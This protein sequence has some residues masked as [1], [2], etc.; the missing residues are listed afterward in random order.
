[1]KK[2]DAKNQLLLRKRP[3]EPVTIE[4]PQDTLQSLQY[5]ARR[6][7]MSVQALL[8]VYIGHGLRQ[9]VSRF[10]A[11]RVLDATA[12]VLAH[13]I[14]S[15][16]EV[17]AILAEIKGGIDTPAPAEHNTT[18]ELPVDYYRRHSAWAYEVAETKTTD[19]D[20]ALA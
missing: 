6:R 8:K 13:H 2:R 14:Q 11:E 4:I 9:D 16:E 10:F 17:S 15:A 7:D 19:T 5:V 12:S 20:E 1:M 18:V 3:T